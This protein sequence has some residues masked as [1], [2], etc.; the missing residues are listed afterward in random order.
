MNIITKGLGK[1]QSLVTKGYAGSLQIIVTPTAKPLRKAGGP[2]Y[3]YKYDQAIQTKTIRVPPNKK[4]TVDV[5]LINYRDYL[6][7]DVI[8]EDLKHKYK[9]ISVYVKKEEPYD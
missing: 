6:N 7:I 5:L 8:I 3:R 9:D 1:I 4:I 2:V